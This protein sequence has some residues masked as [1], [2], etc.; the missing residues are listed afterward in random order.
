MRRNACGV[1]VDDNEAI[2]EQA[3]IVLRMRESNSKQRKRKNFVDNLTVWRCDRPDFVTMLE[4]FGH[5]WYCGF[6]LICMLL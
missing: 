4:E 2:G 5:T 1:G 3:N 6:D